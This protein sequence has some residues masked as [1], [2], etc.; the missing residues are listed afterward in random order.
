MVLAFWIIRPF[1]SFDHTPS[2]EGDEL[3]GFY[4]S[5]FENQG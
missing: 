4:C 5:S 3:E 2:T 1:L